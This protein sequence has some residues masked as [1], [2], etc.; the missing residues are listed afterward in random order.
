MKGEISYLK[1]AE[2][3]HFL[4]NGNFDKAKN[5]ELHNEHIKYLKKAAYAGHGQAQFELAVDFE[6][7]YYV[8]KNPFYNPSRSIYWYKKACENGVGAAYN[9]LGACFSEGFG[10]K[11][12]RVEALR[13]YKR[14][15]E[16]GDM[17]SQRNYTLLKIEFRAD[18]IA[19][20]IETNELSENKKNEFYNEYLKCLQKCAKAGVKEYQYLLAKQFDVLAFFGT[21]FN[22]MHN[23]KLSLFWYKKA[24]ENDHKEACVQLALYYEKGVIYKQNIKK[25]IELYKKAA[26]LGNKLAMKK[27]QALIKKTIH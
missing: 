13:L 26:D 9:N 27:Y 19:T 23:P 4:M 3:Y 12:D 24:C 11:K 20:I 16:L 15:S 25:A 5:N 10:C 2:L 22:P 17:V 7:F 1:A 6:T 14:G 18:E 21:G 8:D